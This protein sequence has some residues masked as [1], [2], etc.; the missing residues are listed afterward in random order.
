[1]TF[2]SPFPALESSGDTCLAIYQTSFTSYPQPSPQADFLPPFSFLWTALPLIQV[3][4]S[5]IQKLSLLP[6]FPS[7]RFPISRPNLT[8]STRRVS[9]LPFVLFSHCCCSGPSF[10]ITPFNSCNISLPVPQPPGLALLIHL[11]LTRAVHTSSHQTTA[12][13]RLPLVPHYW[14]QKTAAPLGKKQ[15]RYT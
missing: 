7:V 11:H 6:C 1:M 13:K 12:D 15:C 14:E 3:S 9:S 5:E 2:Q 10:V 8:I 4:K